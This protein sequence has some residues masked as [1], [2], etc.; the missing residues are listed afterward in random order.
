MTTQDPRAWAAIYESRD[1]SAQELVFRRGV[2]VAG[3]ACIAEA[4][5][6]GRW[7]DVGCGTGHLAARLA[8]AGLDVTGVDADPRMLDVAER[9]RNPGLALRFRA[10]DAG[11]L[12]FGDG[13]L[14]GVVA[15]SVV[16]CLADPAPF[17]SEVGRVLRAGGRAVVTFT[18]RE[19]VLHALGALL[20]SGS[21]ARSP[22]YARTRLYSTREAVAEL[23]RAG[24]SVRD[25]RYYNCF[26]SV[27]RTAV[28]PRSVALR[29]EGLLRGAA[30]RRIARN[31]LAVA[32]KLS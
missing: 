5:P 17:F 18:N 23:E 9:H 8:C 27:G 1:P 30:G 6:G 2:D 12:P 22:L 25:V 16:G 14:D 15:T 32:T 26:V 10:G 7:A 13:T 3:E 4:R 31:L 21:S 28:P 24:L 11:D 29:L 20:R 19:S